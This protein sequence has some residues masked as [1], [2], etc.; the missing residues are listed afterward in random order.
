MLALEST[1]EGFEGGG[2]LLEEVMNTKIVNKR[3]DTLKKDYKNTSFALTR[4][5]F[6]LKSIAQ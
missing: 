2:G 4:P 3:M 1:L 5:L 6:L